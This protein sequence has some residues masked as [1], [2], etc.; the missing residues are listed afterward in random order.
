MTWARAAACLAVCMLMSG[1]AG[2]REAEQGRPLHL[3]QGKYEGPPDEK[4]SAGQVRDLQQ[5]G[6]LMR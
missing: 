3:Q 5:R 1:A 2:C 6:N 4:L